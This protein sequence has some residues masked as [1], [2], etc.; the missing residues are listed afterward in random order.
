MEIKNAI[1]YQL[2]DKI[3]FSYNKKIFE[4]IYIIQHGT[5]THYVCYLSDKT[6]KGFTV[7]FINDN[8]FLTLNVTGKRPRDWGDI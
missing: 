1:T 2:G 5:Y 8:Q 4:G 6:E 3:K 7:K